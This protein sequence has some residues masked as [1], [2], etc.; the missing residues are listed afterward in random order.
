MLT[1]KVTTMSPRLVQHIIAFL[2]QEDLTDAERDMTMRAVGLVATGSVRSNET[3]EPADTK[4]S[5][6]DNQKTK[7]KS[8][9]KGRPRYVIGLL[10]TLREYLQET[11]YDPMVGLSEQQIHDGLSQQ[12]KIGHT[13]SVLNIHSVL[14]QNT[15]YFY[16][17]R[18]SNW[19]YRPS[20]Q[21]PAA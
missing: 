2:N 13:V 5:S 20:M 8:K 7:T 16:K 1:E 17:L 4:Q 12:G 10:P 3:A 18:N 21:A 15:R 19:A 9:T 6:L 14:V 11:K